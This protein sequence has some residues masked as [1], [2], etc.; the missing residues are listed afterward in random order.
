MK[1]LTGDVGKEREEKVDEGECMGGNL[2]AVPRKDHHWGRTKRS[3]ECKET[4][5][6]AEE[7]KKMREREYGTKGKKSRKNIHIRRALHHQV[8]GGE[9]ALHLRRR[10]KGK[11]TTDGGTEKGIKGGDFL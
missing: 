10:E 2:A 1:I 9:K 7:G 11:S 5:Q 4:G 3:R 8:K 6:K